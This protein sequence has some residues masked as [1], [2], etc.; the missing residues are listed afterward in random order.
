[1]EPK[2]KSQCM[3]RLANGNFRL[4]VLRSDP[5]HRP[6]AER[7]IALPRPGRRH[8]G[9]FAGHYV[10]PFCTCSPRCSAMDCHCLYV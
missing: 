4:G 2:P 10:R 8:D 3:R 6:G 9:A 1:V 5:R 7:R